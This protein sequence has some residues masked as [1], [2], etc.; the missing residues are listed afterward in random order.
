MVAAT[1]HLCAA[2]RRM[3]NWIRICCLDTTSDGLT[4]P[5][6]SLTKAFLLLEGSSLR[7]IS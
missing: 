3:A 4:G 7:I 1:A 2:L 6:V 5:S